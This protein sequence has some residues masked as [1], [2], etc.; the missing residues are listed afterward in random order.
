MILREIA[1]DLLVL[2]AVDNL[3]EFSELA[4]RR[5]SWASSTMARR[6]Q[7]S[8]EALLHLRHNLSG[9]LAETQE[10]AARA[11]NLDEKRS[12]EGGGADLEAWIKKIDQE[13]ER[14]CEGG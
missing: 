13:L 6:R 11:S 1:D 10:E 2:G 12:L 5:S 9:I 7:V 4:G 3:A 14:R 8:T